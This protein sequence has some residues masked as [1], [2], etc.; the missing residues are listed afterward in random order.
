MNRKLERALDRRRAI[1]DTIAE[2]DANGNHSA[3]RQAGRLLMSADSAVAAA[4]EEGES[5][6]PRGFRR[7]HA[8]RAQGWC[9]AVPRCRV[10]SS[11]C[12]GSAQRRIGMYPKSD[13]KRSLLMAV[14][15][16]A[17]VALA[18]SAAVA[19]GASTAVFGDGGSPT[20]GHSSAVG[21]LSA[22]DGKDCVKGGS[23]SGGTSDVPGAS[24]PGRSSCGYR[25]KLP[26]TGFAALLVLASG[27]VLLGAGVAIRRAGGRAP[28]TG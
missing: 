8:R 10:A 18:T 5:P 6:F 13:R 26:F 17:V 27:V 12:A 19:S 20:G 23:G 22:S 1:T 3:A 16:V 21:T 24:G 11:H 7:L 25:G 9:M 15:V 14:I 28:A 4:A 2:A